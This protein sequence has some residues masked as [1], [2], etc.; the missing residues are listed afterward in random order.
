MEVVALCTKVGCGIAVKLFTTLAPGNISV[1]SI[2]PFPFGFSMLAEDQF[3]SRIRAGRQDSNFSESEPSAQRNRP[4]VIK[5]GF[6]FLKW[7]Y[8]IAVPR[9]SNTAE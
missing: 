3:M 7:V 1:L 8:P 6:H 2:V 4:P 9:Q 5:C